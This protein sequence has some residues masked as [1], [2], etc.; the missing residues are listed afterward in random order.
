MLE[1]IF[2]LSIVLGFITFILGVEGEQILYT[3]ISIL[4]WII[5]M[6]GMVFVQVP[7]DTYYTEWAYFAVAIGFLAINVMWAII[8]YMDL[9]YWRKNSMF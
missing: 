6:A 3:L 9:D 5:V 4:M 8:L 2:V 7:S 1:S